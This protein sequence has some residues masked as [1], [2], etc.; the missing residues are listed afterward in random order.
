MTGSRSAPAPRRTQQQRREATKTSLV[1]ATIELI[2]EVGYQRATVASICQRAGLSV[3][4]MFR[5]FEGRQD[6]I[7]G[8]VEEVFRQYLDSYTAHMESL[9]TTDDPLA[10]SL[11]FLQQTTMSDLNAV[12]REI[13]TAARGDEE[14]R[15]RLLPVVEPYYRAVAARIEGLEL[16]A[17]LPRETREPLAFM[18][19]HLFTG[20][21]LTQTVFPRPDLVETM[22]GLVQDL[23]TSF[24][25]QTRRPA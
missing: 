15:R 14:L 6:L 1:Q 7:V 25:A 22:P 8:A 24:L 10:A 4:A 16:F 19:V 5:Q 2:G 21:A 18:V 9:S 11:R 13:Y 3:G 20:Q 23:L 17:D 12:H